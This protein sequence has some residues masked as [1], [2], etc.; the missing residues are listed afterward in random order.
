[1]RLISSST[2]PRRLRRTIAIV[3]PTTKVLTWRPM[4]AVTL[5]GTVV[6]ALGSRSGVATRQSAFGAALAAACCYLI[7]DPGAVTIASSPTALPARRT[8]RVMAAVVGASVG[9]GTASI[10]AAQRGPTRMFWPSTLEFA[11]FVAVGLAVSA[12]ATSRGAGRSSE[13]AGIVVTTACFASTF[14]PGPSWLP[15][16]P[17]PG[18]PGAT[19]RLVA[20]LVIAGGVLTAASRDPAGGRSRRGLR[21]ADGDS[22]GGA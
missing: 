12:V 9:W 11:T 19:P 20:V 22:R 15:F 7:D 1:V 6:V 14:L 4:A 16:P 5:A 13:I 8:L 3:P 10:A 18:R 21:R 17:D 2:S